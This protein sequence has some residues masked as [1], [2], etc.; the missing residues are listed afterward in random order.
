MINAVKKGLLWLWYTIALVIIIVA[1]LT[2]LADALTPILN[3]HRDKLEEIVSHYLKHPVTINEV[4]ADWE[5]YGLALHLKDVTVY[6]D[7]NTP[8]A[9][10]DDFIANVSFIKSLLRHTLA[11]RALIIS[12]SSVDLTQTGP[13][14]FLFN[15]LVPLEF[16]R[17]KKTSGASREALV[18]LKDQD[19]LQMRNIIVTLHRKDHPDERLAILNF[20]FLPKDEKQYALTM[21]AR[22][23]G[24]KPLR[25][26][27]AAQLDG[28]LTEPS[29]MHIKSYFK[30]LHIDLG[31]W[32]AHESIEHISIEHGFANIA[33]WLDYDKHHM[34]SVQSNLKLHDLKLMHQQHEVGISQFSGK[35]LWKKPSPDQW[36]LLG[37]DVVL[38]YNG[39]VTP[40]MQFMFIREDDRKLNTLTLNY[41]NVSQA[42]KLVGLIENTPPKV[43]NAVDQIN[44]TG[45]L[46]NIVL[47]AGDDFKSPSN[48]YLHAHVNDVDVDPYHNYP[49]LK[50]ISGD[51]EGNRLKGKFKLDSQSAQVNFEK[52]FLKPLVVDRLI[53]D[54]TWRAGPDGVRLYL[55][56]MSAQNSDVDVSGHLA[57]FLPANQVGAQINFVTGFKLNDVSKTI[58]YLPVGAFDA[59]LNDWLKTA[60]VSGSGTGTA[61]F[62]GPVRDFPFR[63]HQGMFL[64]KAHLRDATLHYADDWPNLENLTGQLEFRNQSM[65]AMID[66]GHSANVHLAHAMIRIDDLEH[67]PDLIISS[68]THEKSQDVLD[69]IDHSPLN[70]E[71]GDWLKHFD[72]KGPL[73]INFKVNIPLSLK[74]QDVK[75]N[76]TIA[77]E[78]NQLKMAK[79]PSTLEHIKGNI[80]FT[81]DSV[82][83]KHLTSTLENHPFNASIRTLVASKNKRSLN[84]LFNSTT[85]SKT[86]IDKYQ[87]TPLKDY[88][89]GE[90]AYTG[91]ISVPFEKNAVIT[92]IAKSYLKGMA[93]HLPVPYAK[94]AGMSHLLTLTAT[95]PTDDHPIKLDFDYSKLANVVLTYVKNKWQV[96][97]K[98][99]ELTWPLATKGGEAFVW[100]E[101]LD[102]LKLHI[103]NLNAYGHQVR[104]ANLSLSH[105]A[106]QLTLVIHAPTISGTVIL[107]DDAKKTVHAR[108]NYLLLTENASS[109]QQ[110]DTLNPKTLPPLDL[111]FQRLR[112][113]NRE[114]GRVM[115]QTVPTLHGLRVTSFQASSAVYHLN[116]KGMWLS[117]KRGQQTHL[118]GSLN[119]NNTGKMLS[120][121]NIAKDVQAEA[122]DGA[123]NIHWPGSPYDFSVSKLSGQANLTVHNGV[124]PM[125]EES[126]QMGLGRILSLFSLQSI[127][128]RLHLDFRDLAQKGYSFNIMKTQ[129]DLKSGNAFIEKSYFNGPEARIDFH[130]SI[131]LVHEK[132]HLNLLVTPYVTSTLPIIATIAGG[133]IAGIATYAFDKLISSSKI[134]SYKYLLK[135]SWDHPV[136]VEAP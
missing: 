32:L 40:E 48:Y 125:D 120:A 19:N 47:Q 122:G 38:K 116:A 55:N 119:A 68:H 131:S 16:S 136:L 101:L 128:R 30:I 85:T 72:I 87:L 126:A 133:P 44:P 15:G 76:G 130:G 9:H 34:K 3:D 71:M 75:V 79:W 66:S 67:D 17:A 24:E 81:Q 99:S 29:A 114:F 64:I 61:I 33:L 39:E 53:T 25:F 100:P 6:Q 110:H 36:A 83:A 93:L 11:L 26:K 42:I 4:V 82:T 112:Y 46:T 12:G 88:L 65:T 59:S 129:M 118:T 135:G 105:L 56:K 20:D 89:N 7:A 92:I 5:N 84:I 106:N 91:A 10:V 96:D 31:Q 80:A 35:F 43:L 104:N 94:T 54:G 102:S 127:E 22:Y 1:V 132:Y 73:D 49:G 13:H 123:F 97:V 95:V 121:L 52:I 70:Q 23:F 8:L 117:G 77:L 90:I 28:E 63:R 108:F 51:I 50:N 41:L 109:Q 111:N 14:Q 58:D 18:W 69:F 37:D 2:T 21:R 124:I 113:N 27:M 57:A 134:T 78:D 45:E 103:T 107:P 60:F 98:L 62:R 74:R 86:L 115:L